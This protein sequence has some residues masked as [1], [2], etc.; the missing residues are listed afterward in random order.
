VT[1]RQFRSPAA[2]KPWACLAKN[3]TEQGSGLLVLKLIK[4]DDVI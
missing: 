3:R 2:T 4:S 1:L